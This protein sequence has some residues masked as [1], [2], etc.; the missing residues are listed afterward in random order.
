MNWE[1]VKRKNKYIIIPIY[2]ISYCI[3]YFT[4]IMCIWRYWLG[5]PCPGCGFTR[6]VFSMFKLDFKQAWHYHPMY[7]SSFVIVVYFVFEGDVFKNK[8]VNFLIVYGIL[9]GFILTWIV[10]INKGLIV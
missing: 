7:W 5:I 8:I 9:F 1:K 2:I 3:S 4:G 6:A 10:R